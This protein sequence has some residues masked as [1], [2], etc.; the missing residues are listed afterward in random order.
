MPPS[1]YRSKAPLRVSFAGGGTDM[2]PYC[3]EHGGQVISTTIDKYIYVSVQ[4]TGSQ[5]I[6]IHAYDLNET[7]AL[8]VLHEGNYI[9]D[10]SFDLFK[11]V[12][13]HF[14]IR[15]GCDI[16]VHSDL[17][18]GSGMGTSSSLTVALIAVFALAKKQS[19]S[20]YEIAELACKIE[21]EE[22]KQAGGYQDQ[23]A[24]AFGGFN[25]IQF[26]QNTLVHTLKLQPVFLEELNHR[27]LLCF[28]GKT[29]ISAEIQEQVLSNYDKIEFQ[30][31]MRLLK[32][33]AKELRDILIQQNM[34]DL[35]KFGKILHLAWVAKKRLSQKI[36]NAS[37]EK[38]YLHSR[39][40]G[41]IGGKLLGAGGGGFLLLLIEP[42]KRI[43]LTRKLEALGAEVVTFH[44]DTTG[45]TAWR[46]NQFKQQ[47]LF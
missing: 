19:M 16:F 15:K 21:R 24:A 22:L 33:R 23:Y 14:Q 31:G 38:L 29:H 2:P 32:Q 7:A 10:G 4:F 11:A 41:A 28:T 9:F 26:S 45:V 20:N 12:L 18:A 34:S 37:I 5:A 47:T 3:L 44:F 27:L 6:N 40:H 30:D 25:F 39:N 1:I 36:S 13:N 17:P 8:Q 42:L 35:D 46:V 43:T